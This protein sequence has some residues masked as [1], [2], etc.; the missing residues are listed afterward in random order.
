MI[1]DDDRIVKFEYDK[2]NRIVKMHH[3]ENGNHTATATLIYSSNDLVKITH[4]PND[5]EDKFFERKKNTIRTKDQNYAYN[6]TVNKDGYITLVES[7]TGY[8]F[9]YDTYHYKGGNLAKI[10]QEM[11]LDGAYEEEFENAFTE[12]NYDNK[13][14]PFFH[15]N[16]PK[17][18]FQ[19]YRHFGIIFGLNNNVIEHKYRNEML[20]TYKYEYDSDGF[21]TKRTTFEQKTDGVKH[22]LTTTFTYQH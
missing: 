6:I 4:K 1:H 13:K 19:H 8:D 11:S 5:R 7:T 14:S 20:Q 3:Y 9:Y 12:L 22:T 17:W 15:C 16:T 18:F 2:Q 21:P 10:T